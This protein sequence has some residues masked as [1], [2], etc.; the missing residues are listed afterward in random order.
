[1]HARA[2]LAVVI[3]GCVAIAACD[4]PSPPQ[5]P[6][7]SPSPDGGER[8]TGNERLGWDQQAADSAELASYRYAIYVDGLRSELADVSCASTSGPG[9]FACSARL[10]MM[11][12]G[13]HTLD[14]A[15]FT[16]DGGVLESV[17]S[18]ALHVI[19]G[20][21]TV[22][23]SAASW[24]SGQVMTTADG[25]RLRLDLVADGLDDPTDL[26][27]APDGRVFVTERAGRVRIVLNGQLQ[28]DPALTIAD[29][30]PAREGGLVALTLD[31]EF[32][33]NGAVY[34]IYTT[35][36]G[37]DSA[38]FR[39][40]RFRE[41]NGTI[42]E[43]AIVL[44]EISAPSS[45]P[46]AAL[47][48]G[49]DHKLY[50]VFDDGGDP[51]RGGDLGSYS[52]KVLRLNSDGT[53][54]S[55]HTTASPVYAYSLHSPHG[56]DWQQTTGEL[57]LADTG[58]DHVERLNVVMNDE[59]RSKRGAVG[60]RYVL[61]RLT[62]AA[63]MSFYHGTLI[64]A[65]RGDLLI[66]AGEGRHILRLQFDRRVP[67]QIVASE[68]LLEDQVGSLRVVGTGARGEIY[69]CTNNVLGRLVPA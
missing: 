2:F 39:L 46:A 20:G 21:T 64:P 66:A 33:R 61:P 55:D 25:V 37:N 24:P 28:T 29:V 50:A 11:S 58:I 17:R 26:S 12:A 62:G 36:S 57:W 34:V 8:I 30:A 45:Q 63:S 3:F 51:R 13:S 60:P 47:R 44:D 4:D 40:A 65:L 54:P 5:T 7:P 52:G 41:V 16:V 22:L 15:A 59:G 18:A 31:P 43:R 32:Q 10:P 6:S 56:I 68:R 35:R 53:T 9:G 1:M 38:V 19:V 23:S 69:F 27:V 49:P 67:A 14:L 48:F 42:A